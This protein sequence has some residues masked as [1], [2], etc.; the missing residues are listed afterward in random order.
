MLKESAGER[1]GQTAQPLSR[2]IFVK[3][4]FRALLLGLLLFIPA[5]TARWW[6]GWS[7]FLLYC[8]WSFGN[9]LL[10]ARLAPALLAGRVAFSPAPVEAWDKVFISLSYLLFAVMILFCGIEGP[11]CDWFGASLAGRWFAFLGLSSACAIATLSFINNRF[12][13]GAVLVQQ[14]QV[15]SEAGPYASIR[16]RIY[17][18]GI[19]FSFC[20]PAA[21]GSVS[22][23]VPAALL[24]AAIIARTALEDRLLKRRLPGYAEYAARVRY[25]LVPGFW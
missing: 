13:L 7:Y 24:S 16:H 5:G 3:L 1:T 9:A 19:C 2:V 25:R 12:A 15:P 11:A 18:A 14:G 22:A 10:L 6:A 4:A 20:T 17:L 8:G 23:F 21:L